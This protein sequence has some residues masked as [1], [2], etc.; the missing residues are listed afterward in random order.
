[1]RA[2]LPMCIQNLPICPSTI[3][4]QLFHLNPVQCF[5]PTQVCNGKS[6]DF[7]EWDAFYS[8][9]TSALGWDQ[10]HDVNTTLP[11]FIDAAFCG[12]LIGAIVVMPWKNVSMKMECT[13]LG[14][15]LRQDGATRKK[16]GVWALC[17]SPSHY[18]VA[19]PNTS[20]SPL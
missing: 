16:R 5:K 14:G 10:V 8:L 15:G 3:E 19:S 4:I 18:T 7:G 6:Q 17:T 2:C 1:M 13:M 11:S 9:W 20:L 12:I